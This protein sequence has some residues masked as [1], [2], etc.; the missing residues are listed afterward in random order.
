VP[1]ANVKNVGGSKVPSAKDKG[2]QKAQPAPSQASTTSTGTASD[3]GVP[4][5]LQAIYASHFLPALYATFVTSKWPFTL[6]HELESGA[7]VPRGWKQRTL[8]EVLQ[9]IIDTLVPGNTYRIQIDH[10]LYK[11]VRI[12]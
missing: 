7:P 5:F 4:A 9:E 11:K 10:I 12:L 1:A 2:K 8:L 3:C 6:V